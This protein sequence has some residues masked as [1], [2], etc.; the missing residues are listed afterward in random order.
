L[1]FFIYKDL[2]SKAVL[3]VPQTTIIT[4]DYAMR[5]D[6]F[7]QRPSILPFLHISRPQRAAKIPGNCRK[8]TTA[9]ARGQFF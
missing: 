7:A 4:S 5:D 8:E 9:V 1:L 2:L 3:V 6:T